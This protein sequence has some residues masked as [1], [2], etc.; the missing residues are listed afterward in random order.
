MHA[1]S[2][3][4]VDNGA[5]RSGRANLQPSA[6]LRLYLGGAVAEASD[7][8]VEVAR[9]TRASRWMCIR[10]YLRELYNQPKVAL[11]LKT[12]MVKAEVI[13]PSCMDAVRGPF[14]RNTMLNSAPY[15]IGSCFVLSG[16]RANDQTI[17]MNKPRA[18]RD[19]HG[20]MIV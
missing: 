14:A 1:S 18:P 9:W 17:V 11:S 8:S 7:V 12:R 2:A 19:L 15:T 16:H 13:G 6:I 10:W 4:T 20:H 5:G 3:Y